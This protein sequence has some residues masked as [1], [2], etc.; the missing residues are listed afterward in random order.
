[1]GNHNSK[2]A[3]DGKCHAEPFAETPT[4]PFVGSLDFYHFNMALSGVCAVISIVAAALL[5][6]RHA[7]H[8]SRPKQQLEIM[9]ITTFI[10]VY[11]AGTYAGIVKPEIYNYI[12]PWLELAQ[13]CALA[14]FYLLIC[15]FLASNRDSRGSGEVGLEQVYRA[16]M[17]AL[18][19]LTGDDW[20]L[21][22]QKNHKSWFFVF[23]YPIVCLVVAVLTDISEAH[24]VF[25]Y[26]DSSPHFAH[27]WLNLVS[28]TCI[29]FAVNAV[30]F[31]VMKL[32]EELK[33][34][35]CL[36]KLLAFKL[37]IGLQFILQIVYW[38]LSDINP[39]P[40]DPTETMNYTD[41]RVGVPSLVVML[42]LVGFSIL[43]HFAYPVTPY[44]LSSD[45]A[46]RED[47]HYQGGPLGI[48]ALIQ[49]LN[50]SE[51][52][53]STKFMFTMK[54]KALDGLQAVPGGD[55]NALEAYDRS[56]LHSEPASSTRESSPRGPYGSV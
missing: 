50:P 37:L 56:K 44:D 31:K 45:G 34:H 14:N 47:A 12:Q 16:P 13:A 53:I 46:A 29:V 28:K 24:G 54:K 42:E 9:R 21:A 55:D 4:K 22:A 2:A 7:T 41:M 52:M 11:A 48:K 36:L 25:C 38:I 27:L 1:M 30:I 23:Q 10:I 18:Q 40:L 33:A 43:F 17:F 3:D 5:L 49:M 39:S 15:R 19:A 32:R 6:F 51:F 8:F 20:P 35:R 26:N